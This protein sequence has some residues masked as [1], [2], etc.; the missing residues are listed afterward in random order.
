MNSRTVWLHHNT[1]D[2][3]KSTTAIMK[4]IPKHHSM[5]I[6]SKDFVASNKIKVEWTE[7]R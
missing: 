4:G 1:L 3:L 6:G 2:Q 5:D 7:W